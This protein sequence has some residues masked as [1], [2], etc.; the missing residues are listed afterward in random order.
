MN[1]SCSACNLKVDINNYKKD[2][3]VCICCYNK[4]KR[5]KNNNV[6]TLSQNRQPETDNT[7]HKKTNDKK[8]A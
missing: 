3:T 1:Q 2:G 4:K 8:Q 6:N 7:N 5:K